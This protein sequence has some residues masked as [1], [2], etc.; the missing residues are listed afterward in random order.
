MLQQEN[1]LTDIEFAFKKAGFITAPPEMVDEYSNLS[2]TLSNDN[3][4]LTTEVLEA[5]SLK[6]NDVTIRI[7]PQFQLAF[8]KHSY[9]DIIAEVKYDHVVNRYFNLGS[10]QPNKE[11]MH[12]NTPILITR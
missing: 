7:H 6:D 3:G 5:F 9:W 2:F 11:S 4:N 10:N 12:F 8:G 1:L